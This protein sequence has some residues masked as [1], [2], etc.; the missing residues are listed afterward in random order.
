VIVD[1]TSSAPT[2]ISSSHNLSAAA[3]SGNDENFLILRN[4]RDIADC[5]GVE[6][7]RLYDHYRTRWHLKPDKPAGTGTAVRG[8][9]RPA[10]LELTPDDTWTA[11]YFQEGTLACVD[12]RRF[13]GTA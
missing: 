12:R 9:S 4:N 7:M 6:A 3:S 5:Y 13:A 10:R 2:V 1:F 11:P 8:T